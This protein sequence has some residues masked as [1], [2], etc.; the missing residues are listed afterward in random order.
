M[1]QG[2]AP[3][4]HIRSVFCGEVDAVGEAGRADGVEVAEHVRDDAG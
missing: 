4:F 2:R 1:G 3:S